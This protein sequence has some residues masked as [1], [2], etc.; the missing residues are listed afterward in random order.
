MYVIYTKYNTVY[1]CGLCVCVLHMT[2]Q[3]LSNDAT[4]QN[5][6]VYKCCCHLAAFITTSKGN[7]GTKQLRKGKNG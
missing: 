3:L 2:G 7:K 5:I 6:L 1:D 4:W